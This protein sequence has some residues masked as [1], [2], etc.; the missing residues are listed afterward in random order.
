MMGSYKVAAAPH[1]YLGGEEGGL[2]VKVLHLTDIHLDVHY[3]MSHLAAMVSQINAQQPD[4]VVFTGDFLRWGTPLPRRAALARML[5]RIKAPMGKYAVRGN[6][7][8]RG[9]GRQVMEILQAAGFEFLYNEARCLTL[10]NGRPF[11]VAGL[12]DAEFGLARM[13]SLRPLCGQPG[14]KLLL[15]HEP[16]VARLVPAGSADLI[17]AGHTHGGQIHLPKLEKFWMPDF[18]GR[19]FH[20]FFHVNG[21]TLY[22]SAGLGES[23]LPLRLFCP[24][25][26]PVFVI[27]PGDESQRYDTVKTDHSTV[28]IEYL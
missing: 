26:M 21:A 7:D 4:I 13:D 9:D 28:N 10:P 22:V 14:F 15:A 3:N 24:P 16:V 23:A 25:E 18:C 5:G 1:F 8:L 27:R 6:H 17:L 2:E 12:D 20:G 11:W 19:F